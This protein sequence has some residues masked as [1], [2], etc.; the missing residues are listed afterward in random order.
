[1]DAHSSNAGSHRPSITPSQLIALG[2][3][4]SSIGW[5]V[6]LLRDRP[7]REEVELLADAVLPSSEL[8]IMEAAFDRAQLTDYRS[9][10]GRVWVPR[11]RQSAYM[12]ALVDAEALPREFGGSL[13]RALENNSPWQSK[14]VQAELMRVATQ[15][16]LA[17]VICSM[18]GIDRAAV[19]YDVQ[20]QGASGGLRGGPV[21]T[22]SV[23]VRTQPGTELDAARV[24]A[25][26]VLVA[27]SIAGLTPDRVAV[28]DLRNGR[29][30]ADPLSPAP[31][32][33][34]IDPRLAR[35]V[36]HE[37]H[38]AKKVQQAIAFVKG[39]T[40]DVTVEFDPVSPGDAEP[41]PPVP[42]KTSRT[43]QR[44]AAANSPAEV[45]RAEPP[46]VAPRQSVA[47]DAP[48]RIRVAIAVP[49]RYLHD[50]IGTEAVGADAAEREL[51]RIRRH[52][53]PLLPLTA[54]PDERI[55]V[56]TS[57]AAAVDRREIAA[58]PAAP[59]LPKPPTPEQAFAAQPQAFAAQPQAFAAQPREPVS[60]EEHVS[61]FVDAVRLRFDGTIPIT[62]QEWLAGMIVSVGLFAGWLWWH[63]SRRRGASPP[64]ID[65][66][67]VQPR[68]PLPTAR[69]IVEREPL[70]RAAA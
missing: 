43:E 14:A 54:D 50:A 4:A 41:M 10:A 64:S 33:A 58:L 15:D 8:A 6:W 55:V 47:A 11:A 35:R 13:R 2:L 69:P 56:V 21:K 52:V 36:A 31:D 24:E 22:A 65:W 37:K 18:P 53:M 51:D 66:S 57:F 42:P 16:E 46:R 61:Q 32:L 1:M 7:D 44:T 67:Q 68:E 30:H 38:L 70:D 25:I 12:R 9:E 39:A 63:G 28:T 19:L 17:L 59:E 20:E 45:G 48:S 27:S 23:S 5:A 60:V 40:V 62:K 3:V 26:R 34:A 49:E 29:V